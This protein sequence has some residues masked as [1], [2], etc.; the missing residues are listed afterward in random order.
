M[1]AQ[2]RRWWRI[3]VTGYGHFVFYGTRDEADEQRRHKARWEGG[4]GTMEP[5]RSNARDVKNVAI[6]ILQRL[7]QGCPFPYERDKAELAEC[8]RIANKGA[9]A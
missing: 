2:K 5:I 3:G 1:S 4:T 6:F 7:A 9:P 8:Q